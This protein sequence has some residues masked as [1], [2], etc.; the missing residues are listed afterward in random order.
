MAPSPHQIPSDDEEELLAPQRPLG[1]AAKQTAAAAAA[2]SPSSNLA[3]LSG[4]GV[5]AGAPGVRGEC[6]LSRQCLAISQQRA[7]PLR[8]MHMSTLLPTHRQRRC[9]LWQQRRA[10]SPR[11]AP[12]PAPR[13]RRHQQR[14]RRRRQQQWR[15]RHPPAWTPHSRG[16]S[17]PRHAALVTG[18][19]A[20]TSPL[21][22]LLHLYTT[23]PNPLPDPSRLVP[24]A[25]LDPPLAWR[26][27]P[28]PPPAWPPLPC[29]CLCS[30]PGRA[31]PFPPRCKARPGRA[32]PGPQGCVTIP[33]LCMGA[34]C[35][36]KPG[37]P[38]RF[39]PPA[40]GQLA[41]PNPTLRRAARW[42]ADPVPSPPVLSRVAR[43]LAACV[44]GGGGRQH[45]SRIT[46]IR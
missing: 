36:A 39:E 9:V 19:P 40:A 21:P 14:R 41:R 1:P 4:E 2:A 5:V 3:F 20:C 29:G 42:R 32:S 45:S 27:D 28:A 16:T 13:R 11:C 46:C 43:P 25:P 24:D 34:A 30:Q 10:L 37:V 15:R 7:L 26:H 18:E 33:L 6:R 38:S 35:H 22:L 17:Q 44:S 8:L 12:G 31:A 23:H